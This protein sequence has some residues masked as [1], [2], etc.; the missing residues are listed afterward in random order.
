MLSDLPFGSL[1]LPV[2]A[3]GARPPAVRIRCECMSGCF[4]FL[5]LHHVRLL[6]AAPAVVLGPRIHIARAVAR[7]V[8]LRSMRELCIK[9]LQYGVSVVLVETVQKTHR[10]LPSICTLYEC[11]ND[12]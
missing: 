11:N 7:G 3:Q 8:V 12:R 6:D 1:P 4:T 10:G 2:G 9:M 5:H